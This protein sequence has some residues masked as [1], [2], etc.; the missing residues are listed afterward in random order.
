MGCKSTIRNS[1]SNYV[2]RKHMRMFVTL[3]ISL[4]NV[5]ENQLIKVIS[6]KLI[7]M[8]LVRPNFKVHRKGTRENLRLFL[9]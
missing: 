9:K 4:I 6:I 5:S 8:F 2:L 7:K 3:F 1:F